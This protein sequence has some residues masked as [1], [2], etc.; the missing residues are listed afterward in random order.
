MGANG[1]SHKET[2]V[3]GA[4]LALS[5][6]KV[7]R[8]GSAIALLRDDLLPAA[9]ESLGTEHNYVDGLNHLLVEAFMDNPDHT[10]DKPR[11]NAERAAARRHILD[12]NTGDDLLLAETITQGVVERRRRINGPTDRVTV[13]NEAL[14]AAVREKLEL[15]H[16]VT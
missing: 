7:S 5:L 16:S 12:V 4:R 8:Y 14:L 3:S 11:L 13:E 15:S 9:R 1:A 6:S 10:R 2:I